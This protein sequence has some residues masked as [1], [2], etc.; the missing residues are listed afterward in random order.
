[1]TIASGENA[2]TSHGVRAILDHRAADLVQL[3]LQRMGGLTG[4]LKAAARPSPR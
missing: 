1:M 4:W 3:D 2:Y